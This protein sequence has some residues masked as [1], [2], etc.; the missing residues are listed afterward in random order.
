MTS[1]ST[2]DKQKERQQ[3]WVPKYRLKWL[4][5]HAVFDESETR[6]ACK[7][8]GAVI[9]WP[10]SYRSFKDRSLSSS[11]GGGDVRRVYHPYCP[12]CESEPGLTTT[13]IFEE[14]LARI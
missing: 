6:W 14:E 9:K 13:P 11:G 3:M 4:E 7:S 2:A 10:C 12:E 1:I 8:T 5:K